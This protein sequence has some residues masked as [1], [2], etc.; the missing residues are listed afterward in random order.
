[1]PFILIYKSSFECAK[2]NNEVQHI[3]SSFEPS[4]QITL[5]RGS[6]KLAHKSRSQF[7]SSA[8]REL[9][10]VYVLGGRVGERP[11]PE[12]RSEGL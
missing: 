5:C 1:M 11:E 12:M 9:E 8:K 2:S 6:S 3:K 10:F 7:F 4:L